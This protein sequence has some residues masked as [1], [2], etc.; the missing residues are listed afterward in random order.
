MS[1]LQARIREARLQFESMCAEPVPH[2]LTRGKPSAA[3][4]EL[5]RGLMTALGPDDYL[6][7]HGNDCRNYGVPDG[8]PEARALFSE[9]LDVP[10][11]GILIGEN[12]SLTLMHHALSSAVLHGVPGGRSPW[13]GQQAT[14]LCPVPG[15]DR[16]FALTEQ[17]GLGM[18]NVGIS[19]QGLDIESIERLAA[20]DERIKGIWLVPKYQNPVGT[21]LSPEEVSALAGMKTAASDFRIFWDNAYA[22]HH[23]DEKLAP[24]ADVLRACG[25]AGNPD[26]V[27]IFGSTSKI[28]FAGAGI[29]AFNESHHTR[30]VASISK[31]LGLPGVHAGI[32]GDPPGKPAF[33]FV[34]EGIS[35]RRY[36]AE[37]IEGLEEPRV[38]LVAGSDDPEETR[39]ALMTGNVTS[40]VTMSPVSGSDGD[41][42]Y[43]GR[44]PWDA[45]TPGFKQVMGGLELGL[46][47]GLD[48]FDDFA[49]DG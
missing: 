16:H 10:T 6:D 1:D 29:S 15:Y 46:L 3:Q 2:D 40:D 27:W 7:S 36:V 20:S 18:T 48:A 32:Q 8:L 37:P 9:L 11:E 34:W 39:D 47:E 49:V 45:H 4:L 14:I 42:G 22:V 5:S 26:R 41:V 23:I 21:T 13:H 30:N 19:E 12:S 44:L 35:W 17:L 43:E 28:S 38:Y 31:A 24:V 25:E 33:T